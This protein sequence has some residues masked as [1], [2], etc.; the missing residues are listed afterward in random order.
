MHNRQKGNKGEDIACKYLQNKG[1]TIVERNYQKAWGELDI[2]AEKDKYIHFFEVKSVSADLS[3]RDESRDS[4][5]HRPEENVHA[6]KSRHIRR[7]V[8]TYLEETGKGLEAEFKFHVLCVFMDFR[9]RL[10]RVKWIRDI[11]L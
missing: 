10:S 4:V 6:L 3:A 8:A 9:K 2:I 7:V 5:G 11:I 1:F